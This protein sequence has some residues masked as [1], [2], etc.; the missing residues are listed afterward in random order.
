MPRF[1]SV[2]ERLLHL[3]EDVLRVFCKRRA[4]ALHERFNAVQ[5]GGYLL[6]DFAYRHFRVASVKGFV[7]HCA[8]SSEERA[9]EYR[10]ECSP[11]LL[12]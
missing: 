8:A 7:V 10:L 9:V 5:G 4:S 12:F 2:F 3:E 11:G 6:L 1:K